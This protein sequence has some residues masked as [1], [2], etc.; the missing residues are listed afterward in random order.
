[1]NTV[2]FALLGAWIIIVLL[3]GLWRAAR[4]A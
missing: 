2:P 4:E 1:M 3:H